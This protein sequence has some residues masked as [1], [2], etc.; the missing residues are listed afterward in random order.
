MVL[1]RGDSLFREF[2]FYPIKKIPFPGMIVI[3]HPLLSGKP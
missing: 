2:L 3:Y 1:S